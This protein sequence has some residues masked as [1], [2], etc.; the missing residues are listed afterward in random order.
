[1]PL[2][3]HPTFG[4]IQSFVYLEGKVLKVYLEDSLT[5]EALWDTADVEYEN[6]K[7]FLNA[8]IRYHCTPVGI[9]RT[10]G[11]IVDGGRGFD[12]GD[13]VVLMAKIGTTPHLGEEYEKMYV[14]SHRDGVVPCSYN[15]LLIRMSAGA[16]IPHNPPYG[17]WRGGTY[18]PN[19]PGSHDHEYCTTTP[20]RDSHMIF[21]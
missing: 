12:V 20:R 5:A 15:Y 19:N 6:H 21:P 9:N 17:V 14:V 10:N 1:M 3:N 16:F 13:Q 11:A 4:D 18:V 7:I 2:L 8:A